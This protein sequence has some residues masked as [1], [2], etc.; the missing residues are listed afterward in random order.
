MTLILFSFENCRASVWP[1]RLKFMSSSKKFIF[2]LKQQ[3]KQLLHFLYM[4]SGTLLCN[5]IA[6]G[7]CVEQ[8]LRKSKKS[9][10]EKKVEKIASI[11]IFTGTIYCTSMCSIVIVHISW[12][13]YTTLVN[14]E[15][16]LKRSHL[17]WSSTNALFLNVWWRF[18]KKYSMK[19]HQNKRVYLRTRKWGTFWVS[20]HLTIKLDWA[21]I[22]LLSCSHSYIYLLL[23]FQNWC[24]LIVHGVR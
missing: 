12:K 10:S 20:N 13:A 16:D 5:M 11:L 7:C 8:R 23:P 2:P 4:L 3:S 6:I 15:N 18:D 22:N 17:H 19:N 24:R 14:N 9:L 21:K 1:S